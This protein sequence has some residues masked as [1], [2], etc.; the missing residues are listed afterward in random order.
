[1]SL[2]SWNQTHPSTKISSQ[3]LFIS[4]KLAFRV[5]F[6]F[7]LLM[8]VSSVQL[9]SLTHQRLWMCPV[10]HVNYS[11]LGPSLGFQ[12]TSPLSVASSLATFTASLS[13]SLFFMDV[14][15]RPWLLLVLQQRDT[16]R[17]SP[18]R[19]AWLSGRDEVMLSC[20]LWKWQGWGEITLQDVISFCVANHVTNGLCF[21]KTDRL[22]GYSTERRYW[23]S[24]VRTQLFIATKTYNRNRNYPGLFHGFFL[25][26]K[27]TFSHWHLVI[28]FLIQE[29]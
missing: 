26:N 16:T 4:A 22:L 1:M 23:F 13:Q 10:P 28:L 21:P 8:C 17:L 11:S 12:P 29:Q 27:N 9:I 14:A 15:H 20:V 5:G 2:Q 19:A 24:T 3:Q 6:L 18:L 25:I 7:V